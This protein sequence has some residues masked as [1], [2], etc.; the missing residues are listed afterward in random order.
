MCRKLLG[1]DK[2]LGHCLYSLRGLYQ[3]CK[4]LVTDSTIE[5]Y[6]WTL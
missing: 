2:M 3:V 1:V 6:I 5:T 4:I